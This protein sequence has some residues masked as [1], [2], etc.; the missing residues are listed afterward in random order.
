MGPGLV[1]I[2]VMQHNI[3]KYIISRACMYNT[4]MHVHV[5]HGHCNSDN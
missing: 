4:R 1:P 2:H 5:H 3:T